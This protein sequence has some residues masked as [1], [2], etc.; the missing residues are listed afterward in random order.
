[1]SFSVKKHLKFNGT[2][3]NPGDV[4]ETLTDKEKATLLK[5]EAVEEIKAE[6]QKQTPPPP[7]PPPA[8]TQQSGAGESGTQD[9]ANDGTDGLGVQL[10]AADAREEKIK[11]MSTAE[12][13]KALQSLKIQYTNK[14]TDEELAVKLIA[15]DFEKI[16]E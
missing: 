2:Q 12:K 9:A 14:D 7:P 8:G 3:Y 4:I 16:A 11:A 10:P 13:R 15:S 6:E 5:L 1:M